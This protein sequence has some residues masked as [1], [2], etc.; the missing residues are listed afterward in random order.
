MARAQRVMRREH[1]GHRR[2]HA[3]DFLDHDRETQGV[4][5]SA[6]VFLWNHDAKE[7]QVSHLGNE[8]VWETGQ[9]VP[10]AGARCNFRV[11]K[12]TDRLSQQFLLLTQFKVHGIF[13]ELRTMASRSERGGMDFT[14]RTISSSDAPGVKIFFTPSRLRIARSSSGTIPPPKT[15]M[16][17]A[18]FCLSFLAIS[19]KRVR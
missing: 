10:L 13:P 12:V 8:L 15:T 1:Q 16:S 6:P 18:L 3:G 14:N 19:L 2:I 17:V 11:R 7:P 4:E 9:L 5:T